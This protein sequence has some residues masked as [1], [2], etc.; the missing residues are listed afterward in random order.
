MSL[1]LSKKGRFF[2]RQTRVTL[3]GTPC[4]ILVSY[5]KYGLEKNPYIQESVSLFYNQNSGA[6]CRLCLY[7]SEAAPPPTL[8]QSERASPGHVDQS[9][10]SVRLPAGVPLER[11][12]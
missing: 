6:G 8:G 11:W 2:N 5:Y 3:F 12:T 7:T 9:Q 1:I 10:A 4:T